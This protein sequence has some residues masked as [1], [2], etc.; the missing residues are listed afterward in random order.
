MSLSAPDSSDVPVA[1]D[2]LIER[3]ALQSVPVRTTSPDLIGQL[4]QARQI[5]VRRIVCIG[6]DAD[7]QCEL[8]CETLKS[9]RS[10]VD[11]GLALLQRCTGGRLML[12]DTPSVDNEYPNLLPDMLVR[13]LTCK[14]L[15]F[16]ELPTAAGVLVLDVLT[17]AG[18]LGG[19]GGGS[20]QHMLPVIVDDHVIRRRFLASVAPGTPVADVL[21]MAGVE[22]AGVDLQ[23]GPLVANRGVDLQSPVAR[24]EL[25]FHVLPPAA[26]APAGCTRCGE[27]V[28]ACPVKIHPAALLEAAQTGS[29][30][31]ARKFHVLTCIE[32]GLCTAVCP[33]SLPVKAGVLAA[34]RLV[35]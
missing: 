26:H 11:R 30:R 17:A 1:I 12:I 27:C 33:S 21:A 18:V 14:T 9:R 10:D 28:S 35:A 31:S 32:C 8:L 20:K 22:V 5:P 16:G 19:L 23:Q 7:P 24:T 2:Q 29:A 3:L 6:V 13:R 25:W 15:P 34:K 4:R